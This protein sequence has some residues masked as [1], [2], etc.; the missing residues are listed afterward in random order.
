MT[1]HSKFVGTSS[2][3][4]SAKVGLDAHDEVFNAG[5]GK[6]SGYHTTMSVFLDGVAARFY[7]G[8]GPETQYIYPFTKMNFF[9]GENNAGKSVILNLIFAHIQHAQ[10]TASVG[11]INP[12]ECY[13]GAETGQMFLGVGTSVDKVTQRFIEDCDVSER[14]LQAHLGYTRGG[15][16]IT[17]ETEI[18]TILQEIARDGIIWISPTERTYAFHP[19][20]NIDDATSWTSYWSA[21]WNVLTRKTHGSLKQHWI[22]DTLN[23]LVKYAKPSFTEAHMIPAK[24]IL[25]GKDERFDDVSGKGLIDYLATLQ[26]PNW[27]KQSDREKFNRIIKFLQDV[28][29]KPNA[30]LEVPSGREHLLVHMDNKVLPLSSLGTGIHE[31]ILIAAFCTI[32]DKTIMCIEEPE[33][34]L[35]PLLQRKLVNYLFQNTNS[36]YFIAT[37]SSVFVDTPGAS[38]FRVSSDGSQTRV[39]I[40]VKKNDQRQIINDLGYQASDILQSNAVV[41]VEGPSDRIYVNHWIMAMDRQ[42]QE[43]I[44]YTIMFYGGA[45]IKHLTASDEALREFIKLRDL[46]RNIVILIDSD[47]NS[48]TDSLKPHAQRIVDEM[49]DSY[50][51][52][53][54]TEGREVENYVDGAIL[55]DALKTIHTKLY[56]APG[57]T[58]KY[59]HSFYFFR[60]DPK[61]PGRNSTYK[62]GD[63]VGAAHIVCQKSADLDMLDLRER[64]SELVALLRKANGLPIG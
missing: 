40:A 59:D 36:Q 11:S 27:D 18:R 64:M 12:V 60:D 53:W 14:S 55:Q 13:R 24:R 39:W 63:K 32:H 25:G 4:H 31:V 16:L 15:D 58:G 22:P 21:I 10:S 34:H 20:I 3:H 44:H 19:E 43:G 30:T 33:I 57:K 37:H 48:E 38:V 1:C 46:N 45:L 23:Y 8:I 9:I 2:R 47:R 49:R 28:T 17:I 61:N 54:I 51:I 29:G 7:R 6:L 26:N 5:C 35:H 50:G 52:V 62:D 41:W 56:K 42:L